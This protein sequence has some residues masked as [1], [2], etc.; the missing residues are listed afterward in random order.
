VRDAVGPAR[1]SNGN[2]A[3]LGS[4]EFLLK[5]LQNENIRLYIHLYDRRVGSVSMREFL[6]GISRETACFFRIERKISREIG[7]SI[8]VLRELKSKERAGNADT[9]SRRLRSRVKKWNC[10]SLWIA[11]HAETH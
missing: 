8:V 7:N 1:S 4:Y 2:S 11:K 6:P 3:C 5:H 9:R 10:K